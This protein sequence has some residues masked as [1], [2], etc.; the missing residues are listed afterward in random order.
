M[1]S[2]ALINNGAPWLVGPLEK[3]STDEISDTINA[4]VT[5]SILMVKHLL[6]ALEAS[7]GGADIVNMVST[8]GLPN[9]P[10]DEAAIAYHAAKH[11]QSGMS[12]LMRQEMKPRGIRVMAVYPPTFDNLSPLDSEWDRQRDPLAGDNISTRDVVQSIFGALALPRTANARVIVLENM[13]PA[14]PHDG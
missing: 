9:V 13:N 6:S 4:A 2:H 12:D 14:A 5:G 7:E 1:L 11:G 3:L 8:C 10:R